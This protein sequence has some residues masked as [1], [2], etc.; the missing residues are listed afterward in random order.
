[1]FPYLLNSSAILVSDQSITWNL[2]IVKMSKNIKVIK[3]LPEHIQIY[4]FDFLWDNELVWKLD[5]PTETMD[6]NNLIWHF[7]VPWL[8]TDGGRF[9]LLPVNIMKHP[10]LYPKQ[11]QRT[12]D[13]DL[14][15]PIDIMWN[16][17]RWLILDGL[18]R[19]MKSVY[20]GEKQVTVRKID[21]SMIPL[22]R[23]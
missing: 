12:M 13:S 8:H 4:A 21:R 15:F 10:E 14:R 2:I 23:K 16:N 18:P 3:P 7:D 5:V 19:L 20:A 11:Y 22:I 6:I 1:M 9:D 17:D